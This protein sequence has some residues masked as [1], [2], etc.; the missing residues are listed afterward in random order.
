MVASVYTGTDGHKR[1][2]IGVDILS[3]VAGG[4]GSASYDDAKVT[5]FTATIGAAVQLLAADAN[6]V[7]VWCQ[8]TSKTGYVWVSDKVGL[9]AMA[10]GKG[11]LLGPGQT[12]YA[13]APKNGLVAIK[14][15]G[16]ADCLVNGQ[17]AAA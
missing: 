9:G 5:D 7:E 13:W 8:N 16:S 1:E 10:V 2:A 4:T 17:K 15:T 6:A 3:G 14:D 11:A 12:F